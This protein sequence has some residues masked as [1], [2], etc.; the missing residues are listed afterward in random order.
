MEA[1]QVITMK[2]KLLADRKLRQDRDKIAE[3]IGG[4][5][6]PDGIRGLS[7]KGTQHQ[8]HRDG[9]ADR[10]PGRESLADQDRMVQII[11]QVNIDE[12]H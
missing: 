9:E 12:A 8:H 3:A 2:K 5:Q 7:A 6:S 1:L 11:Q 10:G 4:C